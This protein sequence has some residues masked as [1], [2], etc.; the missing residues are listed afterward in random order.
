MSQDQNEPATLES[1]VWYRFIK[2]SYWIGWFFIILF[3]I[4]FFV[5]AIPKKELILDDSYITCPNGSTFYLNY[6]NGYYNAD[7][8]QLNSEDN[9]IAFRNCN[10]LN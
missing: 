6:T 10:L 5:N 9:R 7:D 1:K 2:T 4:I 8:E 3:T